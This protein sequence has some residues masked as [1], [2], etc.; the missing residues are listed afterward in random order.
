MSFFSK[1]FH[2][3]TMHIALITKKNVALHFT[4]HSRPW[5]IIL[6]CECQ[7]TPVLFYMLL[8]FY[9]YIIIIIYFAF[10]VLSVDEVFSS[11]IVR[12]RLISLVESGL[13]GMVNAK[14]IAWTTYEWPTTRAEDVVLWYLDKYYN[15]TELMIILFLILN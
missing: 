5:T 7:T 10:Y 12:W 15:C 9:V 6:C 1:V 8:F 14:W 13:S 11:Y 2:L 4:Y 3:R